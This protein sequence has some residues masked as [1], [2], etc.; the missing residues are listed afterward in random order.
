MGDSPKSGSSEVISA[1]GEP[2]EDKKE[3]NKRLIPPFVGFGI[4]CCIFSSVMVALNSL[5]VKMI[6]SIDAI[7]I[8][9]SRCY[10][11]LL[12]LLPFATYRTCTTGQ[13]FVGPKGSFWFLVLRGLAGSTGAMCE[14]QAIVRLPVGDAVT[15]SFTNTIFTMLFACLCL[16]ESLTIL[17]GFLCVLT[18]TGVF[19]MA[20]PPFLMGTAEF[21]TEVLIGILFGITRA[22]LLAIT[23]IIVRKLARTPPMLNIIYYSIIGSITTTILTAATG[24]FRFPCW[25]DLPF[26]FVMGL[27]GVLGQLGMT[28]GLKYERA[29]TFSVVRAFQIVLIFILQVIVL[30][31]I[32]TTLS[33]IGASLIF[34]TVLIIAVR[35]L[36]NQKR[37]SNKSD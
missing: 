19:L 24:S 31:D 3:E 36:Y 10:V 2:T 7:Q 20:K 1:K 29:G 17:D 13:S 37:K 15:I 18:L 32:P 6:S 11:Q 28:I 21:D 4:L 5:V 14:H 33:L 30:H 27:I 9:A 35:K 23:Y 34:A 8:T 26:V 12:I 16:G 22:V 25:S